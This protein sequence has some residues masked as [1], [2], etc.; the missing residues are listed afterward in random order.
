[1]GDTRMGPPPTIHHDDG[2][3]ESVDDKAGP[4]QSIAIV[5]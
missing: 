5:G 1:M 2:D 4:A 3:E